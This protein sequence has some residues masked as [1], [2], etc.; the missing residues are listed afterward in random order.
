LNS[1]YKDLEKIYFLI[2]FLPQLAAPVRLDSQIS[3]INLVKTNGALILYFEREAKINESQYSSD[4]N[5]CYSIAFGT[6][7]LYNGNVLQHSTNPQFNSG[8]YKLVPILNTTTNPTTFFPNTTSS[9]EINVTLT[10]NDT[11]ATITSFNSTP[12]LNTTTVVQSNATE[13]AVIK[14]TTFSIK[15]RILD[16][17]TDAYNNSK[18]NEYKELSKRIEDYV[19]H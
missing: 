7:S 5:T 6:G 19:I 14:Q 16:N 17:Y 4:L 9:L 15:L 13:P 11:T 10:Y 3:N 12:A 2:R 18:S 8:C 1:I